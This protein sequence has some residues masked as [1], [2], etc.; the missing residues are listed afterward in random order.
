MLKRTYHLTRESVDFI[1]LN[2]DIKS[3]IRESGAGKGLVTVLIPKSGAGLLIFEKLPEIEDHIRR[4]LTQ[5]EGE[6]TV[7]D[8]LRQPV[9]LAPRIQTA[10]L[11]RSMSIPY[12][13]EDLLLAPYEDVILLDCDPKSQR[14]EVLIWVSAVDAPKESPKDTL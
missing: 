7:K 1:S 14:R 13:G 3:A 8:R 11:P 12:D 10:L 5:W 4:W 2:H 9:A 6:G